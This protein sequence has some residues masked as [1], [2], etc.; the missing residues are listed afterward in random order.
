MTDSAERPAAPA[1][2]L[3]RAIQELAGFVGFGEADAQTIRRTAP[4]LLEHESRLT[5]AL[6]DHFL[7]QPSAA[8]FFLREDGE[9]DTERIERRKHSLGRWLRES[10]EAAL[11][12]EAGYY[13][14]GIGLSHSHR[15]WGRG[16]AVPPDL[17]IGAISL[18]QTALASLFEAHMPAPEALAASV[19]WNKLLLVQLSV[20]LLGY[21]LPRRAT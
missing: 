8:R 14:L 10:A 6:Y 21:L 13:L 18:T 11:D 17:M 2:E 7:D 16:G 5:A 4:L 12:K 3:P 15:N 9:P 19:A 1:A 20:F